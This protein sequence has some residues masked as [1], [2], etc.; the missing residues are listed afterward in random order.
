MQETK[1][2]KILYYSTVFKFYGQ[3]CH[4]IIFLIKN[5]EAYYY[6]FI[7]IIYPYYYIY[8]EFLDHDW[9]SLLIFVV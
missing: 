2:L 8:K 1:F 4:N 6:Y 3:V 7:I 5:Y 9:F